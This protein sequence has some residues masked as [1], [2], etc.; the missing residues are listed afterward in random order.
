MGNARPLPA[1]VTATLAPPAGPFVTDSANKS[2]RERSGWLKENEQL[3]ASWARAWYANKDAASSD[4]A[5]S[6]R[7]IRT[8]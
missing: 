4:Q 7:V 6:A 5:M 2:P 1:R 3:A 8:R